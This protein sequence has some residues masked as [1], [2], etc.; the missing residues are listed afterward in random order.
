MPRPSR[1]SPRLKLLLA[2]SLLL[3]MGFVATSVAS[4]LVSRNSIR[5]TLIATELPLTSDNVYSEIHKDLIRPLLI[6][7]MMSRDTFVRDWTLGGEQDL[8]QMARYLKEVKEHYGAFTAFFVSETSRNYYYADGLLK[9]VQESEPRDAWYFRTRTMSDPYEINVDPDLANN[10]ALTIFINY[11]VFDYQQQFIG[12]TGVGLTVDAVVKLIDR[13][14]QRYQRTIYFVDGQGKI[15]VA[16]RNSPASVSSKGNNIHELEGLATIS[17]QILASKD[18]SFEFEAGGLRHYLNVRYI[19]E[20]KWYLMV[21]QE[22]SQPLQQLRRTLLLNLAICGAIT[23]LVLLLVQLTVS[24]YQSRLEYLAATDALT[25]LTNRHALAMLLEQALR[26]AVRHHQPL[27]LILLDIDHFKQINDEHGH[28]QG[29]QVLIRLATTLRASLRQSDIVCRWGGEEFLLVLPS[30][31]LEGAMRVA[32]N[33]R[34]QIADLDYRIDDTPLAIT[35]S[36]GVTLLRPGDSSDSLIA[37]AD[38]LLYCAKGE[39]R[40]RI[41]GDDAAPGSNHG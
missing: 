2:L 15:V 1:L 41:C 23:L 12:A 36:A 34:Q 35:I 24:R 18:G 28:L 16:S 39:G 7:S 6:S 17:S 38:A 4:Y 26:E 20:L 33:L 40:N 29:D 13:Y 14:Q 5:Q 10:D 21:E 19:P 11:R 25:G 8:S 27:S 22:G 3:I 9:Q 31:N 30:T 32:E 37:R